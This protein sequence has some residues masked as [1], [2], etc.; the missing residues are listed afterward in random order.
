MQT[1]IANREDFF[2]PNCY[3]IALRTIQ[4]NTV[5]SHDGDLTDTKHTH[6]FAEL[7]I[8]TNGGGSHWINGTV[9]EV[10]A[11]DIFLI[12]GKTSHYFT[13]RRNLE[14]Y[15]IMFDDHFLR[16]H[17]RNLH[18]MPGFNAFFLFEPT[19]RKRHKFSSRLHLTADSLFSLTSLLRQMVTEST[20]QGI[21]YDLILLSKT[22]EIFVMISREYARS[23]NPMVKSLF[24]LGEVITRL[25]NDYTQEWSV[26]KLS[27]IAS[28][29]PSTLLPVFKEVTGVSPI[30]YLLRVRVTKAAELLSRT[31][32]SISDVARSC[33]F[34][35]SNYFSRQFK[36][37]YN[38]SPREFRKTS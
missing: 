1:V 23:R 10:T 14:M 27:K 9:Y 36:K 33:G 11:G 29:A 3:P 32:A 8:I 16:D 30:E 22:L 31:T 17:L 2:N 21:G 20:A 35:D 37:H 19:Y 24:R 25:E 38:L 5:M 15:N 13:K 34:T 28:M 6:D 26:A 12:Q 4:A 18:T 7:I